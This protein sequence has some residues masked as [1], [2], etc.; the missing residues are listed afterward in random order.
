MSDAGQI[1]RRAVGLVAAAALAGC[2]GTATAVDPAP[3]EDAVLV[4][5][6]AATYVSAFAADLKATMGDAPQ[7]AV[8]FTAHH[9]DAF[10]SVFGM[11]P[12]AA[13]GASHVDLV[14]SDGHLMEG[15]VAV[16]LWNTQSG[17]AGAGPIPAFAAG[18]LSLAFAPGR[19][20]GQ[21][22]L[23]SEPTTWTIAAKLSVECWVPR[24]DGP[25]T[26]GT[27]GPGA[28]VIDPTLASPPCAPFR[29]F[30]AP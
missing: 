1:A 28:L 2:G 27:S 24:P 26:N 12:A 23:G 17:A 22:Q 9:D 16:E 30:A 19:L 25:V 14:V 7:V 10:L 6:P 8:G 15:I 13:W 11:L 3:P 21:M 18:T 5:S 4:S 29:P 20:D